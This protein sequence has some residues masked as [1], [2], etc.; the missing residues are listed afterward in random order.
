MHVSD[1]L[2]ATCPTQLSHPN[3]IFYYGIEVHRD[4]C[5]IFMEYCSGG[6]LR[7]LLE[8]GRIEDDLI[9]QLYAFE[10]LKGLDYLHERKILHR[11][12]MR[13]ICHADLSTTWC[14]LSSISSP[15]REQIS[16]LTIS[17]STIMA[18]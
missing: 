15:S 12:R 17:F 8:G 1:A 13:D 10:L 11:G 18:S 3:I 2:T 4:R 7:S 16:N 9:V 14:S 5:N 6:S